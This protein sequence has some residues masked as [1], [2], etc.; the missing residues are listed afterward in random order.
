MRPVPKQFKGFHSHDIRFWSAGALAPQRYWP[1][2]TTEKEWHLVHPTAHIH[3]SASDMA[4]SSETM[5]NTM[6]HR[7]SQ[8]SKNIK[9]RTF[10]TKCTHANL[11]ILKRKC[12]KKAMHS[13][14]PA[15]SIVSMCDVASYEC[16]NDDL[17]NEVA[18][19]E[20][21]SN[22]TMLVR[23]MS[24]ETAPSQEVAKYYDH[25]QKSFEHPQFT[26]ELVSVLIAT[27]LDDV[28]PD[29][30]SD[31][32][33]EQGLS[34]GDVHQGYTIADA[35]HDSVI[36]TQRRQHGTWKDWV[37]ITSVME[38]MR[39]FAPRSQGDMWDSW[40]RT[41]QIEA[42]YAFAHAYMD[43]GVICVDEDNLRF[44]REPLP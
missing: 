35:F 38:E 37:K 44:V 27:C 24:N 17:P 34:Q 14:S 43:V 33:S 9:K 40:T 12:P 39:G 2:G 41:E 1:A 20:T 4:M 36:E 23:P 6:P 8:T 22:E 16:S 7:C 29:S 21:V 32:D 25:L 26:I 3:E 11:K 5:S 19:N 42:C 15:A 18:S 30:G 10:T 13:K 31:Q 28:A